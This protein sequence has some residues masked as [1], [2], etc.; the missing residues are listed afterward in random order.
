[1]YLETGSSSAAIAST[2]LERKADALDFCKVADDTSLEN[3]NCL[4]ILWVHPH[5]FGMDAPL[6]RKLLIDKHSD[7]F[8]PDSYD[9]R[10]LRPP[11]ASFTKLLMYSNVSVCIS[12]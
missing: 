11:I 1:M 6:V 5:T 10:H 3:P 12:Y 4:T 9:S 8:V 2:H 7:D